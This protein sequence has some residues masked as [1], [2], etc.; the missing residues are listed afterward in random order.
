MAFNKELA[1]SM[2]DVKLQDLGFTEETDGSDD[3]RG[4]DYTIRNENFELN[5]DPWYYVTL[6]RLN[7]DSDVLRLI[8]DDRQELDQA[9][10]FITA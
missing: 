6:R 1:D 8:I 5:I 9:I 7:P 10:E 2:A 4:I 3:P